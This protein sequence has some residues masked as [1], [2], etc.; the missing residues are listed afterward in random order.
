MA[1]AN[2]VLYQG[3]FVSGSSD[4]G[5][6]RVS[7]VL[8]AKV[9]LP[10]GVLDRLR[11]R[12]LEEGSNLNAFQFDL[13]FPVTPAA[14]STTR[15]VPTTAPAAAPTLEN[16]PTLAR[17]RGASKRTLEDSPSTE[18][19][20]EESAW[21][22]PRGRG[23]PRGTAK[24]EY[25][26]ARKA[27]RG[28]T[29]RKL[30]CHVP[31][32]GQ[33][34]ACQECA[35]KKTRCSFADGRGRRA[36]SSE[37]EAEVEEGST[38]VVGRPRGSPK[39]PRLE[40]ESVTIDSPPPGPKGKEKATSHDSR[41]A[42]TPGPSFARPAYP[43]SVAPS[44]VASLL[45][46]GPEALAVPLSRTPSSDLS[47]VS[48]FPRSEIA[49]DQFGRLYQIIAELREQSIV[50][51]ENVVSLREENTR[52]RRELDETRRVNDQALQEVRKALEE[53]RADLHSPA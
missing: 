52:F 13:T 40:M 50:S 20:A 11:A 31:V 37:E 18:H 38:V 16:A 27:C 2:G 1:G 45:N 5:T 15:V 33:A 26:E 28:C 23:R 25:Q 44:P 46:F 21:P 29:E 49:P 8:L 9:H 30:R 32:S 48:P 14:G 10:S 7:A 34:E 53:S 35:K 3:H 6:A 4:V 39:K 51:R 43:P 17:T 19:V 36:E 12:S 22:K 47:L 24:V 41:P 42:P